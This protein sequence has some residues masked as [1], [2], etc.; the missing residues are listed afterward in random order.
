MLHRVDVHLT[1]ASFVDSQLPMLLGKCT[2]V[3][4]EE[5]EEMLVASMMMPPIVPHI[6]PREKGLLQL[7]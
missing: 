3:E 7:E 5:G 2:C 6:L 4:E 1:E